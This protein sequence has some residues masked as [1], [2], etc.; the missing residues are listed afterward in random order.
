MD[1]KLTIGSSP[2][3]GVF[4]TVT[5]DVAL[6]PIGTSRVATEQIEDALRVRVMQTAIA[7]SFVVGSLVCGNCSGFVVSKY[8]YAEE[9]RALQE[10]GDVNVQVI[11][12][13]MTA[14]GNIVLANDTAAV[15]HPGLPDRAVKAVADTLQVDVRRATI[16]GLR[17]V[18]MAG[19]ATNKGVLVHPGVSDS[20]V[21]VLEDVFDLPVDIGTVNFG[22]PLIGSGLLANSAGYLAGA[23]T[24]GPELGRIED[25]LGFI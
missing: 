6:V 13:V 25:A 17:T 23:D 16:A 14:V 7:G 1:R 22:S 15:V 9:T 11:P 3:L 21:D 5:D 12:D 2:V 8:V 20:E 4:A 10:L 19:V 24:T 18:G